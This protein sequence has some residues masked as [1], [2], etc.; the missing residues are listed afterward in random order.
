MCCSAASGDTSGYLVANWILLLGRVKAVEIKD[1]AWVGVEMLGHAHV[2]ADAHV[3]SFHCS[4]FAAES[5]PWRVVGS[6]CCAAVEP[7][8]CPC[9]VGHRCPPTISY[10]I[11]NAVNTVDRPPNSFRLEDAS[12]ALFLCLNN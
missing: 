2:H 7:L 3:I 1:T 4:V 10:P 12:L 11:C 6:L 9:Y 8:S 5:L